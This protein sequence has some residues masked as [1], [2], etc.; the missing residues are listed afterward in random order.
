MIIATTQHH[1][2]VLEELVRAGADL[3]LQNEVILTHSPMSGEVISVYN[4]IANVSYYIIG[5]IHCTDGG[6]LRG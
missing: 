5:W 6:C 3:N 1:V 4:Y 2:L